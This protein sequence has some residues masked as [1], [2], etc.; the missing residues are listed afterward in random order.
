ALTR[1]TDFNATLGLTV[2]G[3]LRLPALQILTPRWV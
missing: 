3:A 1:P 2:A